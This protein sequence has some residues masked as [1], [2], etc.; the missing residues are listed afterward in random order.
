MSVKKYFWVKLKPDFYQDRAIKKLRKM[1]SGDTCVIIYQKLMLF[2][3]KSD[4]KLFFE[5]DEDNLAVQ[6]A[7]DIDEDENEVALTLTYLMK[8]G[9]LYQESPD[10]YAFSRLDEMTGMET[11]SA[12]RMRRHRAKQA[13]ATLPP[14][15]GERH[16]VTGARH[17]V[18]PERHN[19]QPSDKNVTTE[20]SIEKEL[21]YREPEYREYTSDKGRGSGGNPDESPL[22]NDQ[23]LDAPP[24]PADEQPPKPE[25]VP[26]PY[27]RVVEMYN[28]VCPAQGLPRAVGLSERRKKA[29][30]AR[31]AAGYTLE[32]FAELF[33][34]TS[35]SS[36][37]RGQNDRN[38]MANFDWLIQDGNMAKVLSG[39]YSERPISRAGSTGPAQ[40]GYKQVTNNPFL[41]MLQEEQMKN[42][43]GGHE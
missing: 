31:F 2:A 17:V 5:G 35:E 4:G 14:A 11:E 13:A 9:L 8:I 20:K 39:N 3:L 32:S 41:R 36:F 26:V 30:R 10:I 43:G 38:W 34:I 29:I 28:N 21:R 27:S 33:R 19:V 1:P 37:L 15:N 22:D 25:F 6:L 16:N 40:E 12:E 18:A 24:L 42:G 7:L 23:A